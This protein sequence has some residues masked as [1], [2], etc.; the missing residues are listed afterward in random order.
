M[1]QLLT[2]VVRLKERIN[3][4]IILKVLPVKN[5]VGVLLIWTVVLCIAM[6]VTNLNG[7]CK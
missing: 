2:I 1:P 7:K 6:K 5:R 3:K 4:K